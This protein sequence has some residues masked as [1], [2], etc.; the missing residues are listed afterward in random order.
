[1][2][3]RGVA[4]GVAGARKTALAWGYGRP[5]LKNSCEQARSSRHLSTLPC[6]PSPRDP[7]VAVGISWSSRMRLHWIPVPTIT[8]FRRLPSLGGARERL[9][10]FCPDI[11]TPTVTISNAR[12]YPK[13]SPSAPVVDRSRFG[14]SPSSLIRYRK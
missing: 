12:P 13:K 7:R 14:V 8:V 6:T 2:W 4:H 9:G 10:R 5:W 11:L 1:M 3:A